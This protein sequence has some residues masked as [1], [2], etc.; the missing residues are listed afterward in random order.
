MQDS[1]PTPN[2]SLEHLDRLQFAELITWLENA[3]RGKERLPVIVHDETPE[4]PILRERNLSPRTRDDLRKACHTLLRRFIRDPRDD[5]DYVLALLRLA[6]GFKISE[7]STDLHALATNHEAFSELSQNQSWAV[8]SALLDLRA[9]LPLA[10]WQE[11]VTRDPARHGVMAVAGLLNHGVESA[12]QVLPALPDEETVADAL[13]V[14]LDQHTGLLNPTERRKMVDAAKKILPACAPHIREAI[15]EWVQTNPQP[16]T[17]ESVVARCQ[18]KL[19]AAL[20]AFAARSGS[21]FEPHP[22]PARLLAA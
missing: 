12:F 19:S 18:N 5:D 2:A 10:F 6:V 14:V 20:A 9:Q 7:A 4:N 1:F 16:I 15:R 17:A 22:Q 13:Y 21:T 8:L 11:I 3:L